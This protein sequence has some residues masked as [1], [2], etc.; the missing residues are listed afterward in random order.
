[1]NSVSVHIVAFFQAHFVKLQQLRH[2]TTWRKSGEREKK[3]MEWQSWQAATAS[4]KD[5][6][7]W[8]ALLNVLRCPAG[9]M[10]DEM[11][12]RLRQC[13]DTPKAGSSRS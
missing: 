13:Y 8:R 9:T 10:R 4:A 7:K 11:K 3:E 6:D 2:E 5:R 12:Q 1:M